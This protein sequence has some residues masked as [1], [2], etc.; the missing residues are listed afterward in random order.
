MCLATPVLALTMLD[1]HRIIDLHNLLT[2]F[3]FHSGNINA[4]KKDLDLI[5]LILRNP[6]QFFYA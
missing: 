1:A 2:V 6:I 3:Q 4:S 5:L